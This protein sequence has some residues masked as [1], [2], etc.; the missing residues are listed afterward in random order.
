MEKENNQFKSWAETCIQ[1]L[2]EKDFDT[3][4]VILKL[5]KLS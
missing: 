2:N 1:E 4:P 5:Q 3:K